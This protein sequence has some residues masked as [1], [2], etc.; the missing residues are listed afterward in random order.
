MIL[1]CGIDLCQIARI[2]RVHGRF[3]P[4][5]LARIYTQEERARATRRPDPAAQAA[6]LAQ[7]FA[8]K[9]ACAKALGTGLRQGVFWRDMEVLAHPS[10]KP[11]LRLHGGADARARALTPPGYVAFF[12]LSLSDDAGL[13]QAVVILSAIPEQD[14][15]ML[16]SHRAL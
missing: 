13:A 5:F 9:E 16:Q 6:R 10:G 1:G 11:G 15:N 7:M 3:G 8:A 14:A 4:R 12:D 2:A